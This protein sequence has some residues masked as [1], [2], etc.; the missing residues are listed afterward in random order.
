MASITIGYGLHGK[1]VAVNLDK[2]FAKEIT[3]GTGVTRF[4]IRVGTVGLEKNKF[5]DPNGLFY[6]AGDE[7]KFE[8]TRGERRYE[9]RQVNKEAFEL[10]IN[11]LKTGNQ[12]WLRNA[13]RL[14]N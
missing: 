12:V 8:S 10:Y 7:Q 1:E 14:S 9:F 6:N 5:I 3:G 2:C 4:Y 11:F 13:Q